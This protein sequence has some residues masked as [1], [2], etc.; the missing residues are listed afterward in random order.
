MVILMNY[1]NSDSH[2]EVSYNTKHFQVSV[3][4]TVCFLVG[5]SDNKRLLPS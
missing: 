5:K 1:D 2:M 3:V 4:Y